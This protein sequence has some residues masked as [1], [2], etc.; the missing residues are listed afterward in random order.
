MLIKDPH[1]IGVHRLRDRGADHICGV[2]QPEIPRSLRNRIAQPPPPAPSPSV[3]NS[4][5]RIVPGNYNTYIQDCMVAIT[6]NTHLKWKNSIP[7]SAF[8]LTINGI[9]APLNQRIPT[10][11]WYTDNNGNRVCYNFVFLTDG[12]YCA[13]KDDTALLSYT[14]PE[15]NNNAIESVNGAF[16]TSF[17]NVELYNNTERVRP[18]PTPLV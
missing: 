2:C 10:A 9:E 5:L 11:D 18:S 3:A 12:Y 17:S 4:F 7:L 14:R 16:A 6:F 13:Y 1:K 15:N 8:K